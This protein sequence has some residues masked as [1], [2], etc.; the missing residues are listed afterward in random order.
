M[1]SRQQTTVA[2][3]R[4]GLTAAEERRARLV[5]QDSLLRWVQPEGRRLCIGAQ[6]ASAGLCMEV[7]CYR[8]RSQE[9]MSQGEGG[10]VISAAGMPRDDCSIGTQS[11]RLV[12][13]QAGVTNS[14]GDHQTVVHLLVQPLSRE[15][16][17]RATGSSKLGA[18]GLAQL[19][20]HLVEAQP[21]TYPDQARRHGS[22][23]MAKHL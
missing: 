22:R 23:Q 5:G 15:T 10:N 16:L 2:L 13:G 9:Q 14:S 19:L 6:A 12:G 4:C 20:E 18:C 11:V 8:R 21:I 1:H 17:V 3:M 7:R